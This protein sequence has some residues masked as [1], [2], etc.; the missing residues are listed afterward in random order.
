MPTPHNSAQPTE[1]AK[2]VL[3]PGDPLRAR[4]VAETFLRD[5]RLFSSVRNMLGYTGTYEGVPVSVMGSGMGIP[6]ICIY[7]YEL[8]NF[9]DVD[10][11]IRI[12]SAGGI[13]PQVQVRDV[14]L[15]QAAS[16]TSSVIDQFGLSGTIAPVGDYGLLERAVE[17]ARRRGIAYHVGNILSTDLFYRDDSAFD[18]WADMGILGVEMELAGLYL[19]AA[20]AHKKA[21]GIMTVS[22]RPLTG[23]SLPAE[24]RQ[25]TFDDM[26]KIALDVAVG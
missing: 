13:A 26:V 4:H 23:E 14:I 6:S 24:D 8:Y 9:Y 25:N 16:T 2:V 19:N 10:T 3:M 17:S 1:V 11:I 18:K 20:K 21:L 5:P 15:G 22:D 12:G 7:S